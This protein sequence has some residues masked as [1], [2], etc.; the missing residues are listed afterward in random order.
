MD[1]DQMLAVLRRSAGAWNQLR[2]HNPKLRP[3]FDGLDLRSIDLNGADLTNV[4]FVGAN[5]QKAKLRKAD[6]SGAILGEANLREADLREATLF[7]TVL[8]QADM[9]KANLGEVWMVG[10]NLIQ[11]NLTGANLYK[12]RL[13][14]CDLF[15][16]ILDEADLRGA[17]LSES[18]LIDASFRKANLTG[19]YIFGIAAWKLDLE[20]A[21]QKD[22]VIT[23]PFDQTITTVD[24][25][26]MAQFL[27]L[28]LNNSKIRNIIDTITTKVVLIL[29][30]FTPQRKA[31]LDA[32]RDELRTRNYL[33]V[34][35]DFQ[36]PETRDLTE[37]V[38]TLAHMARF[39]IADLTD[40]KSLP[41]ELTRIVP[42]LPSVPIQPIL[43]STEREWAMYETFTRYP[44]VLPIVTYENSDAIIFRL[45]E[46]VID[47]AESKAL[48]QARGK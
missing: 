4:R 29:G 23:G 26:E 22:L 24:D 33:P 44:W 40:A 14:S 6:L 5:L 2:K 39:V 7:Q 42:F 13:Q 1:V 34:L 10:G 27:Y 32:I 21:V 17:D 11:T 45:K 20:G 31:V 46:E 16:A 3:R 35:F 43:L 18:R 30:R 9:R 47:P 41:Q 37:T 15:Q 48:E 19:A 8:Q 36:G 25:L 38:S 28:L 12:A